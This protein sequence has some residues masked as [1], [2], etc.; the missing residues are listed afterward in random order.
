MEIKVIEIKD[1]NSYLIKARE[2]TEY[3]NKIK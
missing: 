3:I 2:L 1:K